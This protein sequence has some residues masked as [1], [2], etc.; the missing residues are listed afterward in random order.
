LNETHP[1]NFPLFGKI[2]FLN[3][4]LIRRYFDLGVFSFFK[5]FIHYLYSIRWQAV[6][7][8][9]DSLIDYS[10]HAFRRLLY[11]CWWNSKLAY[12]IRIH[13]IL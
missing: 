12:W 1:Y 3:W 13:V 5:L 2:F 11:F 9:L 4:I 10:L 8:N 7:C 6:M